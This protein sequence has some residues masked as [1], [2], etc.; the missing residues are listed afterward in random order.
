MELAASYGQKPL[1]TSEIARRRD[2]P[3][4]FL[5]AILRELKDAGLATSSRGKDGGYSLGVKPTN[6]KVGDVVKVIQ[7]KQLNQDAS[8]STDVLDEISQ[9]ATN[10]FFDVLNS[11]DFASLLDKEAEKKSVINFSI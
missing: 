8:S 7:S 4:R 1:A 11:V 6:L 3:V 10:A 2:I 9:S 5:E